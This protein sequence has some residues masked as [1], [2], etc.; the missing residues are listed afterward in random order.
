MDKQAKNNL[1]VVGIFFVLVVFLAY[2]LLAGPSASFTGREASYKFRPNYSETF[3]YNITINNTLKGSNF[4]VVNLTL[5]D[6]FILDEL[7]P[8]VSACG[9]RSSL[10]NYTTNCS[11]SG[12]L[13]FSNTTYSFVWSNFSSATS[14]NSTIN[15]SSPSFVQ[16]WFNATANTSAINSLTTLGNTNVTI[17]LEN[18]NGTS[19]TS[20]TLRVP[21]L[22][23]DTVAPSLINFSTTTP[24]NFTYTPNYVTYNLT[25]ADDGNISQV[26]VTLYNGSNLGQAIRSAVSVAGKT[27]L[28]GSFSGLSPGRYYLNATVNDSYGNRNWTLDSRMF[29]VRYTLT[30]NGTIRNATT[31]GVGLNNTEINV[32]TWH[33]GTN[34]PIANYS[35]VT[36]ANA[37]GWFSI[38]IP[39]ESAWMY[40]PVIRHY[41]NNAT[42]VANGT[43]GTGTEDVVGVDYV[44]Q[45]LPKLSYTEFANLSNVTANSIF[46]KEAGA[47]NIT[48]IGGNTTRRLN[49]TYMVKD[50]DTGY[51]ILS[52]WDNEVNEL[53]GY[54]PINRNY[55]IM[56]YPNRSAERFSGG[57]SIPL[58]LKWNNFT[59]TAGYL[60]DVLTNLSNYTYTAGSNRSLDYRFNATYVILNLTGYINVSGNQMGW[61]ELYVVPFVLEPGNIFYSY[62]PLP[63]NMSSLSTSKNVTDNVTYETL[64]SGINYTI[65]LPGSPQSQEY[66]IFVTA[67]NGSNWYGQFRNVTLDYTSVPAQLNFTLYGLVGGLNNFSQPN[68]LSNATVNINT[69]K[70]VFYLV[71]SANTTYSNLNAHAAVT[72]DY[73]SYGARE[74]TMMEDVKAKLSGNGSFAVPLLN[75][76][77]VKTMK[78]YSAGYAPRRIANWKVADILAN[79]TNVT[80][81]TFHPQDIPG[82][83][84]NAQVLIA[85]YV[86]NSTCD[87]PT[88]PTACILQVA[89]DL[90]TFYPLK[91][92]LGGGK[93]SLRVS[94]ASYDIHYAGVDML[95]SGAP[96]GLFDNSNGVS[97]STTSY[98]NAVRFGSK[99]PKNYQFVLI[100]MPYG[101]TG[102]TGLDENSTSTIT[103]PTFYDENWNTIWSTASNGTNSNA[104]AG[105]Y[106]HYNDSKGDWSLLMNGTNCVS[107]NPT[108]THPCSVVSGDDKVWIRLPHFSGVYPTLTGTLVASTPA[109]T[110]SGSSGGASSSAASTENYAWVTVTPS[111]PAVITNFDPQYGLKEIQIEVNKEVKNVAMTVSR[112]DSWPE[113]TAA[114]AGKVYSYLKITPENLGDKLKVATI[115]ISVPKA[116]MTENGLAKEDVALFKFDENAKKWTGLTTT[117]TQS[118]TTNM[119][120]KAE[121]T[122]F[123]YFAIGEKVEVSPPPAGTTGEGVTAASELWMW[124]VGAVILVIVIVV[125]VVLGKKR[126]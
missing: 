49:F 87:V 53:D 92:I 123:S 7:S 91:T 74:F 77:A 31:N 97:S 81:S 9:I 54:L 69:A 35:Y 115:T 117:Y 66:M 75:V 14:F 120:Y 37:T 82:A 50:I 88:P 59:Q 57:P 89:Q 55:S 108:S 47:I 102:G 25:V 10:N 61:N 16:I 40:K 93:I 51:D 36:Y 124:I 45:I 121:V 5:P 109:T 21:V 17:Y 23:N 43:S 52:D 22:V 3:L 44:G 113:G 106:S 12:N 112:Y 26:N 73:S 11:S 56:I 100:S 18:V 76:T 78:I 62:K 83:L 85:I 29:Y 107:S 67:R 98:S 42:G 39:A 119:Y 125:A 28:F 111:V 34:G 4:S 86:S 116:W 15:G 96:D 101:T 38:D 105:N 27:S 46:L 71:N 33:P 94:A 8:G 65:G 84:T 118:D 19:G 13:T 90:N 114:K 70:S 72:V 64:A 122:S 58:S 103:I 48:A 95:A 126:K 63:Y 30:F 79:N 6:G 1:I 60:L 80:L 41:Y 99:G 68:L 24:N 2:F 32:T 104:F 20:V 110:S